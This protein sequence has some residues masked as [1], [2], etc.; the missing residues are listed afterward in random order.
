M[1]NNE[2]ANNLKFD[3]MTLIRDPIKTKRMLCLSFISF[4]SNPATLP[5]LDSK[6][7]LA[8][9]IEER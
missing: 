8:S 3:G 7:Q 2:I 5:Y 6:V 1:R 9:C 4:K